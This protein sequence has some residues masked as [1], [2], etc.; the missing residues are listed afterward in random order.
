MR[1]LR[2]LSAEEK[3]KLEACLIRARD[4]AEW[5]RVFVI[6]S[7]DEG[8]SVE[9][10]ARLTRLSSWTIEEYLKE[11]SSQ[12]KTKNDPRGGSSSKLNKNETK[13]LEQHLSEITYLKVKDI[14]LYVENRFGKKYSR[15]GMTAWLKDHGFTFKR[16]EKVPGKLDPVKQKQFIEEYGHLKNSLGTA[17]ELYFLDAVHPEY[18]SQAVSGWIK[19]IPNKVQE[20]GEVFFTTR[21]QSSLEITELTERD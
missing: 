9:E 10:L 14:G 19:N 6:L 20:L 12:N 16:P 1:S 11:Y 18:Q 13:E 5:K 3:A 8:Q 2:P 4:S 7:Y 21:E 15:T 17:E